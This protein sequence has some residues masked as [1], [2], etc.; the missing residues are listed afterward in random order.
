MAK[1]SKSVI[2]DNINSEW[3]FYTYTTSIRTNLALRTRS[4]LK[5]IAE[6]IDTSDDNK[7]NS[8]IKD[9]MNSAVDRIDTTNRII[10]ETTAIKNKVE[11]KIENTVTTITEKARSAIKNAINSL[12]K[13]K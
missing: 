5:G 4:I 6:S 13:R 1:K 2:T 3:K 10:E 11:E 12:F 8:A 9:A 7:I